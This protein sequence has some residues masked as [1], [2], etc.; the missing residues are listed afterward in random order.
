MTS[1]VDISR[2]T[3]LL[4]GPEAKPEGS[5]V[6]RLT[7]ETWQL[8]LQLGLRTRTFA[9]DELLPLGPTD[10][11]VYI[12]WEG[13][14]RQDR[15]PLGDGPGVP[16]IARFRGAGQLVG[17]AKIIT[18]D[19]TV[20]TRCLTKTTVIPW[21]ARYFRLLQ[22]RLPE[23]QL[24]LLCSL[25]D[26]N[27]SDELVYA[28]A[29]RPPI[30]RVSR[31][32]AHLAETAGVPDPRTS[33]STVISGPSQKDIAAALQLGISTVEN[34]MRTLR[35]HG[36]IEARYRQFIVHDVQGLRQHAASTL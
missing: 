16:I 32:L 11:D 8:L 4:A 9:R 24:A 19:S 6:Q 17:E 21:S 35:Y 14:V 30:E 22:H 2:P 36:L 1:A 28:M 27:R 10:R 12:I 34:A 5:F 15:F 3:D 29:T 33:R 7:E 13:V 20:R 26:R 25:E 31:L 18:A 23:L